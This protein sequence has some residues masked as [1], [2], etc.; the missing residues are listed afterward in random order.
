M[1]TLT[2]PLAE[3][4]AELQRI[5]AQQDHHPMTKLVI[6]PDRGQRLPEVMVVSSPSAGGVIHA[7]C[8]EWS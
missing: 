8:F 2:M 1:L 5:H 7:S 3:F 4:I 6:T